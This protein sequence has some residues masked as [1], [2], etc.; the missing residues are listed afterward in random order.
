VLFRSKVRVTIRVRIKFGVLV[1]KLLRTRICA[2]LGCNCHTAILKAKRQRHIT[3]ITPQA[4]Y[5]SC[6]GAFV[7]QTAR[8][9]PTDCG[10]VAQWL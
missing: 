9:Q 1:G 5:R 4:I 7:S 10:S 3:L 2:T 6:S 8:V